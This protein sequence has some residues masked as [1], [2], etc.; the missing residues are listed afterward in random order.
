VPADTDIHVP[1]HIDVPIHVS[2]DVSVRVSVDVVARMAGFSGTMVSTTR[3]GVVRSTV[4]G[5]VVCSTVSRGVVP[6][7]MTSSMSSTVATAS[8][9]RRARDDEQGRYCGNDRKFA[10]HGTVSSMLNPMRHLKS[11]PAEPKMNGE[12]NI[13]NRS[14]PTR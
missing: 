9:E 10:A 12:L 14:K 11:S 13:G 8:G 7:A 3:G 1:V 2:V 6:S 5:G 4:S